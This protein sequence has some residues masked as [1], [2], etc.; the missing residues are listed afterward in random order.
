MT[1]HDENRAIRKEKLIARLR[2]LRELEAR[3]RALVLDEA[4]LNHERTSLALELAEFTAGQPV[5]AIH[6]LIRAV[7]WELD[8]IE[9]GLDSSAR[10]E[11]KVPPTRAG[12][13]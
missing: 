8:K 2:T 5:A 1:N 4:R 3:D 6:R 9:L 11:G 12:D 13:M 10:A 7:L